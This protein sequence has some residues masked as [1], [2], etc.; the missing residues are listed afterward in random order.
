MFSGDLPWNITDTTRLGQTIVEFVKDYEPFYRRWAEKWF[1]NFQFVYGNQSVRWSKRWGFAVDVDFLRRV[2]SI[3]MRAQTNISRVALEALSSLIFAQL[4]EWE[5]DACDESSLKGRR[6][7]KIL[8]KL[9]DAY[10]IRL[11][12]HEEFND[13]ALIF[14][15]FGQFASWIDWDANA[16]ALLEIP[17]YKKTKAPIYTSSVMQNPYTG[18]VTQVPV[19]SRDAMGNPMFEDSWQPVLDPSGR[20]QID[21]LFAGDVK[22]EILTPFEYRR[23][24]G[25]SG[26][27]NTRWIQRFKLLDYDQYLDEYQHVEGKTRA[28]NS[29]RP[30]YADPTIY[31]FAIQ[32]FMRMQFTAPPS[33][34]DAF[35]RNESIFSSRMFRNKVFVIEHWDRP[36]IRKWPLGRRV[37]VTN[38]EATHVT[39]PSYSTNTSDGWH[40]AVEAQW[41]KLKPNSLA[42]G[43]M[44]DVIAKNREMNI[45]D[46]LIATAIRRNMGS[47]LL[48]KIGSGID[49]QKLSGTPGEIHEVSDPFG[50]RWLHD[51]MPIPPVLTT[52][53]QMD[54]EDAWELTGAGDALRGQASVGSSSGYQEKQREE[55]EEKRLT[56]AKRAFERGISGIGMK[57]YACLKANVRRLDDQVV[58]YLK[59]AA[60]GEYEIQDV[61]AMLS[62]PVDYGVDVRVRKSSMSVRSKATQQATLL[63]LIGSPIG[64][65]LAQD[66]G[67][68]DTIL[69]FFDAEQ[70]RDKGSVHRDRADRENEVFEDMMRLGANIEGVPRPIVAWADVDQV[71]A[72]HHETWLVANFNRLRGNE[73]VLFEVLAHIE[74]HRAQEM[75]KKGQMLPGT[76]LI[77]PQTMVGLV[78]APTPTVQQVAGY[79]FQQQQMQQQQAAMG[80]QAPQ[81]NAQA[82]QAPR[83]PSGAGEP[84]GSR[85]DPA[86]P[87]GN[88]PSAASR[89]GAAA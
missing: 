83:Q 40:P 73:P 42:A 53:R 6:I 82:P 17:Q 74:Q 62:T 71:H 23:E 35:R 55:R 58:G 4:P 21:R 30:I 20:Q 45:K 88:T 68:R 67:V 13:A 84:G 72:M 24:P 57:L 32:H 66:P 7:Q 5:V 2:P 19:Q 44:N 10:M 29:I 78:G 38:G 87:S 8:S 25:S 56:P 16:G 77:I 75:E 86:A 34:Q 43:P 50:A 54:R 63:E 12:M 11:N 41:M 37:V 70:L 59:R 89:G 52:L 33:L 26:M 49:P 15:A 9:L 31:S 22:I 3:N 46:S 80:A 14:A 48:T 64:A 60:S 79:T 28:Y 18:G 39:T 51:E 47:T 81:G 85:T 61:V 76:S 69:K 65:P 1:E 36:H 27:H